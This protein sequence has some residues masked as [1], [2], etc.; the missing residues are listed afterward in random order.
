M[1]TIY[2]ADWIKFLGQDSEVPPDVTFRVIQNS[3]TF[4]V[5]AHKLVLAAVSP[6]FR[7][8]FYGDQKFTKEEEEIE[9]TDSECFAFQKMINYIY[10]KSYSIL[11]Y[12]DIRDSFETLKVGDKYDLTDLVVL[13]RRAIESFVITSKNVGKV[14]RVV[15]TYKTLEGFD[16]VCQD[17]AKRCRKFVDDNMKTAQDVFNLLAVTNDDDDAER[18]LENELV[19]K[20]LKE[21]AKCKF[22][23]MHPSQCLNGQKVSYENMI[24]GEIFLINHG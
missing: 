11:M 8:M 10:S 20:L 14:L 9:I 19:V 15:E 3:G 23:K 17:L 16:T 21:T 6:V 24:E 13:S 2:T 1:S 18:S 12:S 5:R 22:C 7:K 4:K